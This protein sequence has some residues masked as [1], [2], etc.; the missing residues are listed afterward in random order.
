MSALT[1]VVPAREQVLPPNSPDLQTLDFEMRSAARDHRRAS[2][3]IS[4]WGWRLRFY[5]G[6][7]WGAVGEVNEE[8]YRKSLGIPQSS[9]YRLLRIGQVLHKLPLRDMEQLSL[10]NADLLT[11]VD[12]AIFS[13]F[14]WVHEAQT[15]GPDE[16]GR[17]VDRRHRQIGSDRQVYSYY[18]ARVPLSS[19]QFLEETVAKFKDEHHLSSFGEA[20][21]FMVADVH[22]RPNVMM[23][24]KQAY[25]YLRWARFKM[26]QRGIK[27]EYPE[28]VWIGQAQTML[29]KAYWATR[30][31]HEGDINEEDAEAVYPAENSQDLQ[32]FSQWDRSMSQQSGGESGKESPAHESI[33]TATGHLRAVPKSAPFDRSEDCIEVDQ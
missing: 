2:L 14:D 32:D 18:R 26:V 12:P 7:D 8:S 1:L 17:L 28:M 25:T 4:Y 22:D 30:M 11:R 13:D 20:L 27:E 19:K 24:I 16:F 23:A 21:E 3:R 29:Y 15:L 6:D 31:D 33:F 5:L 9:W 10:T